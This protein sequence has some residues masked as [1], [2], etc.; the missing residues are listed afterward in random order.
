[1][2]TT[3][4]VAALFIFLLAHATER[5]EQIVYDDTR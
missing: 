2:I 4:V 1:M 5:F 3:I